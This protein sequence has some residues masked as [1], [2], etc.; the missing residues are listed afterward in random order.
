MPDFIPRQDGRAVGW[1]ASFVAGLAMEQHRLSISIARIA[2]L[3]DK[4]RAFAEAF[5][6]VQSPST[7][8]PVAR[9]RKRDTRLDFEQEARKLAAIARMELKADRSALVRLGLV[10]GPGRGQSRRRVGLP[11]SA[12]F[13]RIRCVEGS[14]VTIQ[15]QNADTPSRRGLH[16]DVPAAHLYAFVGDSYPADFKRWRFA[17]GTSKSITTIE[18][19]HQI[20]P[21]F[22]PTVPVWITAKWTNRRGE[23]GP[24]ASPVMT[25]LQ[26]GV[27]GKSSAGKLRRCA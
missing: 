23:T 18:F 24:M 11:A 19:D 26:R 27:I 25:Y 7:R 4:Q 1:S 14:R 15:L 16:R 22:D 2:E 5:E 13:V 10:Q 21:A 9:E 12:P 6:L 20:N 17:G 8:S 3:N